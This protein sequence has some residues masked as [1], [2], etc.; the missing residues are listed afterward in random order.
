[1]LPCDSAMEE[2]AQPAVE[3]SEAVAHAQDFLDEE[4]DGFDGSQSA[5]ATPSLKWSTKLL[6]TK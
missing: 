2:K 3:V 6:G 1:M 4:I 5:R